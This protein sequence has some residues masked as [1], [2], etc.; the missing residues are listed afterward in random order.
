MNQNYLDDELG[1]P[2][3]L[4][5]EVFEGDISPDRVPADVEE[6][7]AYV[8]RESLSEEE[9]SILKLRFKEKMP[10]TAIGARCGVAPQQIKVTC[11]KAL[12]KMRHPSRS[13]YLIHGYA[14]AKRRQKENAIRES[15]VPIA[16]ELYHLR[17][18]LVQED[19][20]ITG[21]LYEIQ[22]AEDRVN[23]ILFRVGTEPIEHLHLPLGLLS[24]LYR[25][26]CSY[27]WQLC[28]AS[29]DD[30]LSLR[31]IGVQSIS[32]LNACLETL[33]LALDD[34]LLAKYDWLWDYAIV[35]AGAI[36]AFKDRIKE[37]CVCDLLRLVSGE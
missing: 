36:Q 25:N 14:E 23:A 18:R 12:R 2:Y 24:R 34:G 4:L 16:E 20:N 11:E 15:V 30:L 33:G 9:S 19:K 31:G 10:Y 27:V 3:N 6:G 26:G 22:D 37:E 5:V 8:L 1:Y 35:Q 13:Q 32:A 21:P 28:F 17:L 29:V 7:L